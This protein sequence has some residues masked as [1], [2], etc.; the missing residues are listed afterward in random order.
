M[1]TVRSTF[2]LILVTLLSLFVSITGLVAKIDL[3]ARILQ[4]LFLPVTAYLIYVLVEHILHKTPVFGQKTGFRRV[5]VYYC[6]I[7]TTTVVSL[8]FLSSLN[9][10]QF[11]SSLIFSPMAVY[12]LLLVWPRRK[13]ALLL[14][15]SP[16]TTDRQSESKSL[17]APA[18]KLDVDRRNFL[19]LIGGAG[20]LAVILGLFSKRSGVP[21]FLGNVDNLESVTLK[22]TSGN[23]INPAENSPTEGY[24]I[25]Q[26]DDSMPSYFG[27]VNKDGAWFIMRE[28]EDE[29]FLYTKGD[30]N[31]TANWSSR[32][33]L[34]Y[35]Y[36][37]SVF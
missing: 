22:D 12:F 8:S 9:I 37:D 14:S 33:K 29:A 11:V 34:K 27:F 17:L 24:N 32:T 28:G 20:I 21:S 7:V 10:S 13:E 26:I 16:R 18:P 5:I 2:F 3:A 4:M 19:K 1:K 36:F 15:K 6:F 31:F 35:N 30:A 23:V 25:S